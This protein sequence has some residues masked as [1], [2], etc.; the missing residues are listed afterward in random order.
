M[1]YYEES[2]LDN[3]NADRT[4]LFPQTIA[5]ATGEGEMKYFMTGAT[6]FIGS[7]LSARLLESG[8]KV[9]ALVRDPAR[10]ES[11]KKAGSC[12]FTGDITDAE[13]VRT[14]MK[15]TDGVFHL[16]AI[17]KLGI[18]DKKSAA[19]INVEGTRNVLELM[20][21]LEIK[22]GVYTSSLAVFSDTHGRTVDETYRFGGRHISVYDETKWRAHYEVAVPMMEKG[23]PLV[24]VLPGVVYGPGDMSAIGNGFVDYLNG[25]LKMIPSDTT[26]C[27][28]YIDDVVQGKAPHKLHHR[29]ASRPHR[30]RV[31]AP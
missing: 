29:R 2:F 28:S 6:G 19:L 15:G 7:R 18:R 30:G 31:L 16:A 25:R 26:F 24:I 13:S 4:I 21:E 17:Y 14:A 23:L 27:W 22:K 1:I 9:H 8:H 11:L 10:A 20:K 5:E 12:L 3:E